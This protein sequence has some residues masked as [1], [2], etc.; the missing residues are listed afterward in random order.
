MKMELH[1]LEFAARLANNSRWL[2]T[3]SQEVAVRY[4][5]PAC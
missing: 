4:L 5:W 3:V 1:E 2:Q